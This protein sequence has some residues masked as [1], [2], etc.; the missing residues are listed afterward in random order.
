M[1]VTEFAI[2][3]FLVIRVLLALRWERWWA[4]VAGA[5]ISI[6][7]AASDEWHQ[8]FIPNRTGHAI[9]VAVDSI[10]I[11]IIVLLFLNVG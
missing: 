8:S 1:H 5:V 6:G 9:D 2:L 10:G 3:A 7:Y 11:V 4:I